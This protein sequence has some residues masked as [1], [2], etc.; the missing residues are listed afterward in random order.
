MM[1]FQVRKAFDLDKQ[2]ILNTVMAAFGDTQ[3]QEIA[4]LVHDLWV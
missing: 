2:A 3:G 1:N 4:T